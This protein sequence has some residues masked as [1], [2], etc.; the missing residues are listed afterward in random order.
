MKSFQISIIVLILPLILIVVGYLD[1]VIISPNLPINSDICFYHTNEA[2]LWI[3]LFYID[4]SG[5]A[6][7]PY[8]TN[9]ILTLFSICLI[10]SIY[11]SI[12]IESLFKQ[13]KESTETLNIE[14]Q[15]Y[16]NE[17][18]PSEIIQTT[19]FDSGCFMIDITLAKNKIIVI[20]IESDKVSVS[21]LDPN[22][23]IDF[24]LPD[25]CFYNF[26]NFKNY[27]EKI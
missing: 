4:N 21:K 5:H 15:K 10:L 22:L 17:T 24:S 12:K 16:I 27:M 8:G 7:P 2:P 19:N 23:S 9:H 1:F 3:K 25:E 20:Q 26:K 11:L 18:F 6:E 14:V 13:K